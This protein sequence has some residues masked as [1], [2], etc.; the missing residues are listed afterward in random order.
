MKHTE[1]KATLMGTSE[2]GV[3]F[4]LELTFKLLPPEE[5]S[6]YY[7]TGCYMSVKGPHNN[8]L[9]DVRYEKTTDIEILADRWIESNY[10]NCVN[11]VT[12]KFEE[13]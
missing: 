2:E 10:G 1:M 9:V 7:G 6:E 13:D 12:K 11:S 5:G 3:D 4:T 8:Q